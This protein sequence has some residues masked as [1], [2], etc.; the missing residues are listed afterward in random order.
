MVLKTS[1]EIWTARSDNHA[2]WEA[3]RPDL[4]ERKKL[5]NTRSW[6]NTWRRAAPENTTQPTD[7]HKLRED[8]KRRSKERRDE[9][10]EEEQL[11]Y[12]TKVRPSLT[13]VAPQRESV[14]EQLRDATDGRMRSVDKELSNELKNLRGA[15]GTRKLTQVDMGPTSIR[16]TVPTTCDIPVRFFWIPEVGTQ[17]QVLW[18]TPDGGSKLGNLRGD[19]YK[20]TVKELAWTH[21]S[22]TP[23]AR[24]R[25]KCGTEEWHGLHLAGTVMKAAV[26]QIARKGRVPK[27]SKFPKK[28]LQWIGEGARLRINR[29]NAKGEHRWR[30]AVVVGREPRGIIVSYAAAGT[31]RTSTTT[32]HND[33]H[34][35]G[36]YVRSFKRWSKTDSEKCPRGGIHSG[37][38]CNHCEQTGWPNHC[39][40]LSPAGTAEVM[41]AQVHNRS[42]VWARLTSQQSVGQPPDTQDR[43]PDPEANEQDNVRGEVTED[44]GARG[45]RARPPEGDPKE[46]NA[47]SR[48]ARRR[49]ERKRAPA[50]CSNADVVTHEAGG[51]ADLVETPPKASL[52]TEN[53]A[54]EPESHH[55]QP[56]NARSKAAT[57][58]EERKRAPAARSATDIAAPATEHTSSPRQNCDS[59]GMPESHNCD[60]HGMPTS[61]NCEQGDRET[62]ATDLRKQ[63]TSRPPA[64]RDTTDLMEPPQKV[65]RGNGGAG[66]PGSGQHIRNA[67]SIAAT[68]REERKRDSA[69]RSAAGTT[70]HGNDVT[71]P[72]RQKTSRPPAARGAAD[73]TGPPPK[74]SRITVK[75]AGDPHGGSGTTTKTARRT[76]QEE[77]R[78]LSKRRRIDE[79]G[80]T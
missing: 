42:Q 80:I 57:R 60:S 31:E 69:G 33:L 18:T 11:R 19:W 34:T 72:R 55:Q 4:V 58:R 12:N 20:G 14:L 77:E 35:V 29:K 52:A 56:P 73:I 30:D 3:A 25:Y 61:H 64:A 45:K 22:S 21:D 40:N 47:R 38:G 53:T 8:I 75:N 24:V 7:E 36:C 39:A 78:H 62:D 5:A 23:E 41:G 13:G 16:A 70:T 17:V 2:L 28:A 65:S 66:E 10:M 9:I 68:R 76:T 49:E 67:R 6:K 74:V 1:K 46:P 27:D 59:H 50:A 32:L 15:Q 43:I 26:V 54:D 48:A 63:K 71:N 37:C 79:P 51:A 44:G